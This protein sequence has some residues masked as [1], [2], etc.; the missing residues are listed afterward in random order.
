[1]AT[2]EEVEVVSE[3]KEDEEEEV[4]SEEKEEEEEEFLIEEK[5]QKEGAEGEEADLAEKAAAPK[6]PRSPNIFVGNLCLRTTAPALLDAL[7]RCGTV[8]R[9]F[10]PTGD[11]Q[12]NA[13]YAQLSI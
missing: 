5:G 11:G 8:T 10:M 6:G 4:V 13:G 12:P 2:E 1:M 3:E 7:R 9:V